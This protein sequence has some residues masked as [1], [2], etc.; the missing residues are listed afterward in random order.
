MSQR[1]AVKVIRI[2]AFSFTL[3][4]LL[5]TAVFAQNVKVQ[6]L[7]KGRSG[8]T[9]TCKHRIHRSWSCC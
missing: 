3:L 2:A 4:A 9:M 7:I 8:E 5:T 6:G 1:Q